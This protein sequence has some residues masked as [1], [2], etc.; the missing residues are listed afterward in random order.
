MWKWIKKR[1]L[2]QKVGGWNN[3]MIEDIHLTFEKWLDT[4]MESYAQ[5]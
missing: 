4:P 5:G 1:T 3:S 2:W